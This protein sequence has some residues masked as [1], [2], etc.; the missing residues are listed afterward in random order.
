MLPFHR[1]N[2]LLTQ[3]L[4]LL[5]NIPFSPS[6]VI[7]FHPKQSQ[8]RKNE[9][10]TRCCEIDAISDTVIGSIPMEVTPGGDESA[11]VAKLEG[12]EQSE[13]KHG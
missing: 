8:S 10:H 2:L 3:A 7:P 5:I 9:N 12:E 11:N 13:S 6:L 4:E 1:F